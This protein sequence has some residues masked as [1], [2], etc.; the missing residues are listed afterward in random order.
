MQTITDAAIQAAFLCLRTM[1]ILIATLVVV[2]VLTVLGVLKRL[3]FIVAPI[4]RVARLS[5][6]STLAL[7]T[8]VGSTLS[9]DSMTARFFQE[10]RIRGREALLSAQANTIPA[11]F[12]ECFTYF[13]PVVVPLLGL[14]PGVLYVSAFFLNAFLK[15]GFVLLTGRWIAGK[16]DNGGAP[17]YAGN[18]GFGLENNR[19]AA[20]IRGLLKKT[21][22]MIIRVSLLLFV[23]AFAITLLDKLGYLASVSVVVK[24]L[25][26]FLSIP[27]D[28]FMP[29]CGYIASP[30]AGAAS[31]GT[32]YKAG[33]IS[34]YCTAVGALLGGG[35][36][37]T[38]ATLRYTIPRNIAMFGAR[39]GAVNAALGFCL[40]LTSRMTLVALIV[41]LFRR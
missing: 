4:A 3:S 1:P 32:L 36:S 17:G 8:A 27:D 28:L 15:V 19:R 38:V 13:I 34:M 6:A 41:V 9:A 7:V 5:E 10:G 11:Y 30:T 18:N 14:W 39:V 35:M 31:L 37:L 20:Q 26:A 21:S 33:E 29:I 24:P 2:D 23:S 12:R 40:A 16:D 22:M 25:M